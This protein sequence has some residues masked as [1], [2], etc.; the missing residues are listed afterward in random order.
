MNGRDMYAAERR[1]FKYLSDAYKEFAGSV[2]DI[3][4]GSDEG[5]AR[6]RVL[7]LL[8][9]SHDA[10]WMASNKD[11]VNRIVENAA[12]GY[13]DQRMVFSLQLQQWISEYRLTRG[14]CLHIARW[15]AKHRQASTESFGM[16]LELLSIGCGFSEENIGR[17]LS[18][19]SLEEAQ[20]VIKASRDAFEAEYP[21]LSEG[22]AVGEK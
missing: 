22:K 17:Y 15:L 14:A 3:L 12:E 10:K 1:E 16:C 18:G 7:R 2:F 20:A 4:S 6:E 9:S 13:K 21:E 19:I 8:E 5:G 11:T